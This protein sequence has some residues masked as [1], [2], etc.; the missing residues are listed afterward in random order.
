MA[1]A[2]LYHSKIAIPD[3][4]NERETLFANMIRDMDKT[5]IFYQIAMNYEPCF[6]EE[7]SKEVLDEFNKGNSILKVPYEYEELKAALLF[8]CEIS[9]CSVMFRR[10]LWNK[11]KLYYDRNS[12]WRNKRS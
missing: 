12:F 3:N 11:K 8:G 2:I 7:I 1:K 4:L 6:T 10:E 9:H 5:D